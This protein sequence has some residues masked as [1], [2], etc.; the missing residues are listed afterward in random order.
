MSQ[1]RKITQLSDRDGVFL[2][3]DTDRTWG[4]V[5]GLSIL[6]P[7]TTESFSFD[8][9]RRVTEERLGLVPR[10][11]WKLHQ[12]GY[13]LD[14]PY[15]VEDEDF[16]IDNHLHRIAVPSPGSMRELLPLDR[17]TDGMGP[18]P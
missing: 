7:T 18:P 11:K 2:A 6:D 14:Q 5:S 15:W 1:E 17:A 3:M 10:F 16:D 13:G 8:R 4:H 9:L 12:V